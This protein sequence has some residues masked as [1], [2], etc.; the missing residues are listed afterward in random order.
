MSTPDEGTC[1][2]TLDEVRALRGTA[3]RLLPGLWQA[4][5][6]LDCGIRVLEYFARDAEHELTTGRCNP[7][8]IDATIAKEIGVL[9]S[10]LS[11]FMRIHRRPG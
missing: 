10:M 2:S 8:S 7:L 6:Q 11:A 1:V 3:L 5:A 4:R 9:Q